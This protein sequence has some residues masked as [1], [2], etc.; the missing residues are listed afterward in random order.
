MINSKKKLIVAVVSLLACPLGLHAQSPVITEGD[1]LKIQ[2]IISSNLPENMCIGKLKARSIALTADSIKVDLSENFGD[3]PF[4]QESVKKLEDDI[5]ASLGEQYSQHTVS[6]TIAGNDIENYF[7]SFDSSYTRKHKSFV[8]PLDDTRNYSKGLSGNIVA[9]WP[10]HGWYFEPYLNRWDLPRLP[11]PPTLT[12]PG[13]T[14]PSKPR[15]P[16]GGHGVL[17]APRRPAWLA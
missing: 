8:T 2:Q 16:G 17:H 11:L 6:L 13:L 5:K 7:S 3:V 10:S 9:V 1:S 12:F 14:T 4:T 15:G